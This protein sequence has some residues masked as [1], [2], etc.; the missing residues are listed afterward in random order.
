M[1]KN[2]YGYIK[3]KLDGTE[4]IFEPN[5]TIDLPSS[6]SYK[7]YLPK[8]LDQGSE[9]ICVPCSIT[10]YIN[11]NIAINNNE[12][13][14]DYNVDVYEIYDSRSNNDENNG[15]MIKEALSYLKH[16]GVKTDNGRFKIKGYSMIR[17]E[18]A[19]K[20]AIIMNGIC[21]A[22]LPTYNTP[23]DDF[24]N[25]NNSE[26]FLGGHAI[27]LIGF[28]ENGYIIRNSWGSGYGYDG[29]SH[30]SYED[31]NKFYEIWTLY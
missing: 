17:S 23:L 2:I 15:M 21:I 29:Y 18:I 24:W 25:E 1:S 30:I 19:L 20:H 31:F 5:K 4:H 10:S 28:D 6:Y 26:E 7:N 9:P 11:W 14:K 8:V 16:Y 27:A 13:E 12:D 22:G 3:S